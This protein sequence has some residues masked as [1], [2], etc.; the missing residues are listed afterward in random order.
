MNQY[1]FELTNVI[2]KLGEP[3]AIANVCF[4]IFEHKLS[5]EDV[6]KVLT[7]KLNIRPIDVVLR[8][9]NLLINLTN[10]VLL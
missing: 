6:Y 10:K 9:D 2:I 1:A 7:E 5:A 3:M 8:D 4:S